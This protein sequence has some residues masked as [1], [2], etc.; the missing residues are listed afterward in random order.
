MMFILIQIRSLFLV[1]NIVP[2]W[3]S[4]AFSAASDAL[5][6]D[7]GKITNDLSMTVL[8]SVVRLVCHTYFFSISLC[9]SS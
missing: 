1:S 9:N 2:R 6:N 8:G 5:P 3:A 7:I 4:C